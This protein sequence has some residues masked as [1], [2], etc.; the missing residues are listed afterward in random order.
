MLAVSVRPERP[1]RAQSDGGGASDSRRPGDRPAWFHTA[2]SH[3]W[4][5]A[6]VRPGP[7]EPKHHLA[8]PF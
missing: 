6:E 1:S 7:A 3:L 4:L 8:P 5:T 2:P